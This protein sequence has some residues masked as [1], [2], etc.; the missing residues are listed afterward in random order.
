MGWSKYAEDNME[1]FLERIRDRETRNSEPQ[2]EFYA[3]I[4]AKAAPVDLTIHVETIEKNDMPKDKNIKC[5]DCGKEFI[6]SVGEQ[7]FYR[8]HNYCDPKRCSSC[9]FIKRKTVEHQ[10]WDGMVRHN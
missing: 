4:P 5:R 3:S 1:I 2:V 6:F 10:F 8:K 9:R 7:D